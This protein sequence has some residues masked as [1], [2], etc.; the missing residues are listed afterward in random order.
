MSRR[1]KLRLPKLLHRKL[2]L[3]YGIAGLYDDEKNTITIDTRLSDKEYFKTAVHESI[4]FAQPGL[5]ERQ[6]ISATHKIFSIL[7]REN[8]RQVKQ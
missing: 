1:K 2:S 8:F 3:R 6:V 7:W 5:T 4:H